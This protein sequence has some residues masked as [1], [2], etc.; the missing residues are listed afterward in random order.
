MCSGQEMLFSLSDCVFF[1]FGVL[2]WE[3][4]TRRSPHVS[5]LTVLSKALKREADIYDMS[6]IF[7]AR[8]QL[9]LSRYAPVRAGKRLPL[10]KDTPSKFAA[11]IQDCWQHDPSKRPDMASVLQRLTKM[12]DDE[13]AASPEQNVTQLLFSQIPHH[14]P[15]QVF[16]SFTAG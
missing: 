15:D 9:L 16:C 1:S 4:L 2:L 6:D 8:C 3:M 7:S 13:I 5:W 14:V 12:R 10:P 11:L